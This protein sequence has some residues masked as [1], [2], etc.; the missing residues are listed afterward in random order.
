MKYKRK[1]TKL[2]YS[3]IDERFSFWSHKRDIKESGIPVIKA[4]FKLQTSCIQKQLPN[5]LEVAFGY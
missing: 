1:S 2:R 3:N 5:P 4:R